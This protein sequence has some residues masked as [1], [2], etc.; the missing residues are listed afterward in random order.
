MISGM[1]EANKSLE[2]DIRDGVRLSSNKFTLHEHCS[3]QGDSPLDIWDF[4]NMKPVCGWSYVGWCPSASTVLPNSSWG[5]DYPIAVLLENES[6]E[7]S[8][9]HIKTTGQL[10]HLA[11]KNYSIN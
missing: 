11:L 8:W 3:R 4:E 7:R 10:I 6:G 1:N 5:V 9:C 2:T